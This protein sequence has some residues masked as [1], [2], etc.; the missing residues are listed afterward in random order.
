MSLIS[1]AQLL[2]SLAVILLLLGPKIFRGKNRSVR[3]KDEKLELEKTAQAPASNLLVALAG[4]IGGAGVAY[5]V[6]GSPL[7]A[8]LGLSGGF[9]ILRWLQAKRERDRLELLKSQYTDVLTQIGA[10]TAGALNAHQSLE[11]SVP[12]LPR[13]ARDVFYEV[14]SRTRTGDNPG[15]ALDAVAAETGWHDLKNLALGFR[16]NASMGIDLSLI[17]FHALEAHY[18]KESVQGQIKGAI[19]QNVMTL[20]VLSG[21]PFFVVGMARVVSPEFAAPLFSTLE[22][23]VFFMICTGMIFL[24]NVLAKRMIYRA[25]G[26]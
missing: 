13:P 17:C 7:L 1:L 19:S 26:S 8:G 20:K 23:I 14:L 3:F 18:E 12:N 24:G 5:A 4:S 25:L 15:D 21:L 11:D 9:F 2:I 16:L 6:T 10:A 22:G